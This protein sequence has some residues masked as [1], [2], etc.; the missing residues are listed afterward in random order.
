M[1]YGVTEIQTLIKA[2]FKLHHRKKVD[3]YQEIILIEEFLQ[4]ITQEQVI[5]YIIPRSKTLGSLKNKTHFKLQ[6]VLSLISKVGNCE[7]KLSSFSFEIDDTQPWK[8]I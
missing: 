6:G 4:F 2:D 3:V 7:S 1:H 5:E 8:K